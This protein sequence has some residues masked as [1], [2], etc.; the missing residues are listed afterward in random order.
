V[1]DGIRP[2]CTSESLSRGSRYVVSAW[3]ASGE[4]SGTN[5]V[6]NS[7]A[8]VQRSCILFRVRCRGMDAAGGSLGNC[9]RSRQ[10]NSRILND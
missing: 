3:V 6:A 8:I 4:S 7:I 1:S 2:E 10:E 9:F 5:S